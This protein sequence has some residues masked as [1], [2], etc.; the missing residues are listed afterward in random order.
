M[1]TSSAHFEGTAQLVR[2]GL[3]RDSDAWSASRT[4]AASHENLHGAR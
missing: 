2:L 3:M 1:C 4:R